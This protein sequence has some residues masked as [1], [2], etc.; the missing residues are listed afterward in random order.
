MSGLSHV[1][2]GKVEKTKQY[3]AAFEEPKG[4]KGA[5]GD[6][7]SQRGE[8]AIQFEQE[9]LATRQKHSRISDTID[10]EDIDSDLE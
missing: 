7:G 4:I 1:T 5:Q 10:D 6:K 8:R 2:R 3:R 9:G